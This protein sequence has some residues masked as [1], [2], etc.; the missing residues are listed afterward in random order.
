MRWGR[1]PWQDQRLPRLAAPTLGRDLQTD[2]LIVGAGISG[3]LVA[4]S[5]SE[6]GLAVAVVDRAS[7]VGG[8]TAASTALILADLDRPLSLLRRN[9]GNDPARRIWQRSRLALDA[10]RQRAQFLGISAQLQRRDALYLEGSLLDRSALQVEAQTRREAGLEAQLLSRR[11]T[12]ARYGVR[13]RS[14]LLSMDVYSANPRLLAAGFLQQALRHGARLH[15]RTDVVEVEPG[16]REVRAR[17]A[18]GPVIR[19]RHLIYACGY[20]MPSG[21][22]QGRHSLSSTWALATAPQQ[23]SLWP[24]RCFIWEA[25][26]PYL[27]LRSD[28]RGRV[29]C[30]GEDEEVRNEPERDALLPAKVSALR[31]KLRRLLPKLDTTPAFAWASSFGTTRTGAPTIGAVPSMPGCYAVLAWGGNGITFSMLAAQLLR[32]ELTGRGDGDAP[33]FAF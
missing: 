7:P 19:A 6:A 33:L 25:A 1:S 23:R 17:T 30:G 4:E 13:G 24:G 5:L 32:A 31:R 26:Q 29:L 9:V 18:K 11:Q 2:V 22:L 3:A 16:L 27:Y 8:A 15:A 28:A 10:L 14:S 12:L 20:G 21:I